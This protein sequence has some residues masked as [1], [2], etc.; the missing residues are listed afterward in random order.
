MMW[1]GSVVPYG[2]VVSLFRHFTGRTEGIRRT[3]ASRGDF[4]GLRSSRNR[5]EQTQGVPGRLRP[6]IFVTFGTTRV[7]G[8]QPYAPVAFTPGEI[9]GSHFQGLSRPNGTWFRRGEPRR[10]SSVTPPG[11]DTGTI[12]LVA[13]RLNHYA[14]PGPHRWFL[15]RYLIPGPFEYH[16]EVLAIYSKTMNIRF[17]FYNSLAS[18]LVIFFRKSELRD[19]IRPSFMGFKELCLSV[20]QN[21]FGDAKCP[22]FA[23]S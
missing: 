10:K 2:E 15:G 12:R 8:R 3:S 13:Q 5:P 7:V 14:T 19:P 17:F 20:L 18:V 6:R 21:W 11:I 16:R 9:P 23:T 4:L 22:G 1:K